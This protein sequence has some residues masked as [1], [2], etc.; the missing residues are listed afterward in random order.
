M[1]ASRRELA[2]SLLL[3]LLLS[4]GISFAEQN[5][6]SVNE[7]LKQTLK[8][9]E[10]SVSK[11]IACVRAMRIILDN[12][13]SAQHVHFFWGELTLAEGIQ[14]DR[15]EEKL[16]QTVSSLSLEARQS[17]HLNLL[18]E[19]ISATLTVNNLISQEALDAALSAADPHA[20]IA[21]E[22]KQDLWGIGVFLRRHEDQLHVLEVL[23][24]SS[25]ARAGLK[26]GD[27]LLEI[28][29][30]P[31]QQISNQQRHELFRD[32]TL[33]SRNLQFLVLS[34]HQRKWL[35]IPAEH[36]QY[37]NIEERRVNNVALIQVR[38]FFRQDTCQAI[39]K[40]L[41]KLEKQD[42]K[43]IVLDLRNNPGGLVREAIC[44]GGLFMGPNIVMAKFEALKNPQDAYQI[45]TKSEQVSHLPMLVL[46]NENTASAA[47]IVAASLQDQN[48]AKVIGIRS[49][50]KGTMQSLIRGNLPVYKST[51]RILRASG[52]PLQKFGV[53]PNYALKE[54]GSELREE[55]LFGN[56]LAKYGALSPK[57]GQHEARINTPC[58]KAALQQSPQEA[59]AAL[60][61]CTL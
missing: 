1:R 51:H 61:Q 24:N 56:V 18:A 59:S 33:K 45:F 34:G 50:G 4:G 55:D 32:A 30:V 25:A 48:R 6:V 36:I 40:S 20:H 27:T 12:E 58:T 39:A 49:F 10:D 11:S 42:V 44:V 15:E 23:P 35:S 8:Q 47:E 54:K 37:S 38:N 52:D 5:A 13:K 7:A 3:F 2:W 14:L 46:V 43:G 60:L 16:E 41:R 9:C 31:A 19:K 53:E 28:N 26:E 17:S 22:S 57:R 29:G 21:L